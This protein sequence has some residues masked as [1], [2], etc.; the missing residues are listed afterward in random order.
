MT[1]AVAHDQPMF[2]LRS[3]VVGT[4]LPTI[5]FELGVG[6]MLPIVAAT[7]TSLGASLSVAGMLV[8]LMAV[9]QIAADLPAGALAARLGDRGAMSVAGLLATAGFA[10]AALAGDVP[11]LAVAVFL[12]GAA[13]ASFFL[14]RQSYL[15]DITPPLKRARV[16]STLGGVHRI[17][18]FIGPFAGAVAISL[19]GLAAAYWM[20]AVAAAL[21]VAVVMLVGPDERGERRSTRQRIAAVRAA[22]PTPLARIVAEHLRV[23]ATLGLAALLIGAV[24]G[25]RLTVLP[26]WTESLQIAPEVTSVIF[27]IAGAVDMLLFYPA[28]KVMDSFGRLWVG[29]P[30]MLIMGLA[31]AAL[32][33]ATTI[34]GLV[35]VAAVLGLGNGMSSGILMT[36]GAD[37]APPGDRAQFLGVWRVL[38]DTGGAVGPLV[39][40]AAAGLGYVAAGIWVMATTSLASVAAQLRWVPR[41]SVHASRATRRAAG[42]G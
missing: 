11:T 8:T 37:V 19:G 25:A 23:F 24:R 34:P 2:P 38:S 20:A 21:S 41:Y 18:Q 39:L 16:L 36:L 30:A 32:P 26:L 12:V 5:L 29:V 10:V 22:R 31:L 15:T 4:F 28:G 1:P 35:A 6:A 13:A 9:A 33:L 14:A 40:T 27:G 17:G 42:I 7:A 3:V